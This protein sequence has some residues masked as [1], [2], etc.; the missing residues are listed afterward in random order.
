MKRL[1]WIAAATAAVSL[2]LGRR[3]EDSKCGI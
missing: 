1:L 2:P 3:E